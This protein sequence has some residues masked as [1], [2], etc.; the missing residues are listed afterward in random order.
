MS[1]FHK[2]ST[3][4]IIFFVR[5]GELWCEQILFD[6]GVSITNVETKKKIQGKEAILIGLSGHSAHSQLS[7]CSKR[8]VCASGLVKKAQ[9]RLDIGLCLLKRVT[10]STVPTVRVLT[11]NVV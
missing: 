9:E 4:Q 11:I 7:L 10:N 5:F 2:S 3:R 8:V 6:L 1:S